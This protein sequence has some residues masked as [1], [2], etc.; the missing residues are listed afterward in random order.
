LADILLLLQF[1]P[2]VT[3]DMHG[4]FPFVLLRAADRSGMHKLMVRGKAGSTHAQLLQV[5]ISVG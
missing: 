3:I 1:M 5:N 4:R 2:A